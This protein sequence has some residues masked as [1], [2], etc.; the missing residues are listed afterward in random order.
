[1]ISDGSTSSPQVSDC[2]LWKMSRGERDVEL[3]MSNFG[4]EILD[5]ELRSNEQGRGGEKDFGFRM[6]NFGLRKVGTMNDE[7]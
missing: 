5:W 2:G 3:R 6:S 4:K 7:R 1:M